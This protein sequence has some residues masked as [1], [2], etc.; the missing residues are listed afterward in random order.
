MLSRS[1][2]TC[3]VADVYLTTSG[4][5]NCP[6]LSPVFARVSR[7]HAPA[8]AAKIRGSMPCQPLQRLSCLSIL[9]ASRQTTAVR[10]PGGS[11]K[12]RHTTLVFLTAQETQLSPCLA[13]VRPSTM[14]DLDAQHAAS[15]SRPLQC[16]RGVADLQGQRYDG[17]SQGTRA[18][19][20]TAMD[21]TKFSELSSG[22]A[23]ASPLQAH[24]LDA[25]R[26]YVSLVDKPNAKASRP[27]RS[28]G[29]TICRSLGHASHFSWLRCTAHSMNNAS[30]MACV[31]V[32]MRGCQHCQPASGRQA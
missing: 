6:A 22:L 24:A 29:W 5:D 23:W 7:T 14:R 19:R 9:F 10:S 4:I 32:S 30:C 2:A 8:H 20:S 13:F 3:K 12:L 25:D 28:S 15:L 21:A 18:G 11:G 26:A 16:I 17:A 1:L 27:T 31:D